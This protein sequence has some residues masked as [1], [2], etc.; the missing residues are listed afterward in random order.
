MARSFLIADKDLSKWFWN[1]DPTSWEWGKIH[2][3]D[4]INI[5]FSVTP[6]YPFFHKTAPY[7]GDMN[8]VGVGKN[9]FKH[10]RQFG[11]FRAMAGANYRMV[12]WWNKDESLNTEVRG[13]SST[14]T[15]MNGNLFAGHYFDMNNDH[16]TGKL[17]PMLEGEE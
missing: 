13:L 11:D 3:L 2:Y 9:W 1:S 15:G 12:S 6:L 8:T 5:P 4:Y 14:D 17:K 7:G 10:F 16:L